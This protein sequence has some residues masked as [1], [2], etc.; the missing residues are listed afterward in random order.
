MTKL[1]DCGPYTPTEKRAIT[2]ALNII[3]EKQP[4]HYGRYKISNAEA[5]KQYCSLLL[6]EGS[7]ERFLCV[8]L[9]AQHGLIAGEIMFEGTINSASVYPRE[10]IRRVLELNA[11][12]LIIAHN[13]PSGHPEPS[14][15]DI[16][17]T[18]EIKQALS[19]IDV[20]LLDHLVVG[21][22]KGSPT[23][24]LAQRGDL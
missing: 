10:I 4:N 24:S 12:A 22:G 20:P 6:S 17:L 2:R 8:F 16:R 11:A 9:D 15:A 21:K 5:S 7:R 3:R 19:A 14:T 23:V 13:H 1:T 18:Q